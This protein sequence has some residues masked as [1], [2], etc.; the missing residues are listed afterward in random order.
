MSFAADMSNSAT[1]LFKAYFASL[2]GQV[3]TFNWRFPLSAQ[4]PSSS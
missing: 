2:P 1:V 4:E 3:N